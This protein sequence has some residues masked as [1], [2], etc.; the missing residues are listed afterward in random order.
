M[1]PRP[2]LG[3]GQYGR[4]KT[5]KTDGV[6][7]ARVRFRDLDGAVRQVSATGT[8]ASK[9]ES[10]L[11]DRLA[12]RKQG[13]TELNSETLVQDLA[14]Q[15]FIQRQRDG[16]KYRTLE[17]IRASLDQHII[18]ALGNLRIRE[19]TTSRLDM[20][21][22]AL[23]VSNGP[24]TGRKAR[25]NLSGMFKL[26]IRY[27]AA[28]ANPA[29]GTLHPKVSLGEVHAMTLPDFLR[30]RAHAEQAVQP[31]TAQSRIER[32]GGDPRRRGGLNRSHTIVDVIDFL[33]GTG[34]RAAEVLGVCWEDV[35]LDDPVPWVRIH[36]QVQR[37]K[38]KGLTLVPTKEDDVRMLALPGFAANMLRRRLAGEPPNE[39]GVVFTNVRGNLIDPVNMR[40]VW[41]S[42]F[43]GTEW[44]WVTP[45]TLRKT[46]AT[47]VAA[48]QGSELAAKQLGHASD[49]VTKMHYIEQS[50]KPL[51][52]RLSLDGFGA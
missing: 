25:S 38:G 18:P 29:L 4:M 34:C 23:A 47:I 22:Q 31:E 40:R 16:L 20:F 39:W 9:A 11:R 27:D 44:E 26:A 2:S 45:K 7:T 42:I 30:F 8:T 35:H 24:G 14:E 49:T 1:S 3:I 19:A 6:W 12:V 37:Q 28:T 21:I 46:V 50:R 5:T 32:S 33:I 13:S 15:W 17:G 43:D 41:H 36:R 10:A 52:Q 48:E 51:D